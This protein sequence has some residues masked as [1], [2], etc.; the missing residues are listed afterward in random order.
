MKTI[1]G[2][3][4]LIIAAPVAAQGNAGPNPHAEHEQ[5]QD[6]QQG[7]S[8]ADHH[9]HHGHGEHE[10]DCCK[11]CCDTDGQQG[12][13]M[14]CCAAHRDDGGTEQDHSAHGH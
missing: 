10:M 3:I 7:E 12:T 4:A 11:D 1:I 13:Q 14:D 2:A 5:H 9:G 6:Q 8:T